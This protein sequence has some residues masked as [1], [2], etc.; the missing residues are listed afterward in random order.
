MPEQGNKSVATQKKGAVQKK[1][2]KQ[3]VFKRIARF[4][5]E[6]VAELKKVTWPTKKELVTSSVAVIVFIVIFMV[7]LFGI[8]TGFTA[9]INLIVA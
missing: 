4:Y 9:L 2:A 8:D 7:V 1:A 5:R 3:N 6:V